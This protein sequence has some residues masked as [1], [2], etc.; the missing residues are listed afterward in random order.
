MAMSI[1]VFVF[2]SLVCVVLYQKNIIF[3]YQGPVSDHF[4]GKRF[5][6]QGRIQAHS[7]FDLLIWKLTSRP[8]KWP[9]RKKMRV[10]LKPQDFL[11][12]G[13]EE[14]QITFVNHSTMLI[15][16]GKINILTDPIWS[17]RASPFKNFG[18]RRI[19]SP[20]IALRICHQ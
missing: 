17:E 10:P 3:L 1:F 2:I 7:F 14:L 13:E 15:Q 18:P 16:W 5:F 11:E 20:G 12:N 9:K 6:N 8:A 19:I 4:D